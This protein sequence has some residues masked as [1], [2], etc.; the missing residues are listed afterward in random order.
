MESSERFATIVD[1]YLTPMFATFDELLA[2]LRAAD[3][4]RPVTTRALFFLVGHGA[5][6]PY[7]LTALSGSFDRVDGPFDPER[8][9]DDMC[10]LIMRGVTRTEADAPDGA[11]AALRLR[12]GP[13][14]SLDIL[15]P[16]PP[17]RRPGPERP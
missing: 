7:T 5:G 10:D 8:H 6:G 15:H 2:R 13:E 16:R 1:T 17:A 4:I 11:T 12:A 3:R 14:P 9:A